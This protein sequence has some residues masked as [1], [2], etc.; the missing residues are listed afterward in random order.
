MKHIK[1]LLIKA[2]FYGCFSKHMHGVI[3]TLHL[4]L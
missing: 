4:T 1:A 3:T 2:T